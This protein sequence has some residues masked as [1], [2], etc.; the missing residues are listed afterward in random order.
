V[1]GDGP[2]RLGVVDPTEKRLA[3][4]RKAVAR[5]RS[6]RGRNDIWFAD[7]PLLGPGGGK[8]AFVFPG[9]E[10]ELTLNCG[11]VARHFG[12]PWAHTDAEVGDVGRQG[13]AVFELGR[14]LHGALG[15]LGV[16]P[17]AVAG[18]SLG[19]WTAMAAAGVYAGHEVDAFL[20]GF[21]PDTL[22]VPG[23][24]F[25]AVGAPAPR[26]LEELAGR[27]DVVLSHDNSPNQAMICGPVAAVDTLVARF[28]TGGIVAQV[29]PFRSGFHTPMLRPYLA[30]IH[31]AAA[32]FTLH[33]PTRPLWSATTVSEYPAAEAEV[34][35]LF[36]RHL[37]EPVRFRPL[38]RALH[39]AGFRAFVQVG[40]GQLGSLVGDTLHGEDHLVV[41]AHSAH[42]PGLAQ[43]RRVAT[44]LWADGLDI[45]FTRLPGAGEDSRATARKAVKL[46]LGGRLI[47][48]DEQTRARVGAR[49]AKDSTLAGK[50]PLA[51]EFA[52]LLADTADLASTVLSGRARPRRLPPP[53]ALRTTLD[54]SVETMPYLLDHCFFKQPPQ[55]DPGD[56]WPVVPATTVIDHLMGFAEQT[57]PG[58]RAVAVHDVRLTQW[59]A[60]V[61]AV[62]VPVRVE[63]QGADRVLAALDGYSQA[64]VELA[65]AYPTD[66]PEPWRFPAS[67]EQVPGTTAAELY[68]DRWMFHGPRFQGVTELTAVGEHHVRAVLTTPAAPGA[69]LDNVGQVLGYWIMARFPERT[70]VFPVGMREIRFHGPHPAPG[71]RLECLVRI[72][73]LTEEFL[74]A[75]MQLV[76]RGQVWAEFTGWRDRRFDSTRDIRQADRTPERSTLSKEQPGGW[77]L[78]REQWP[79]LATRELI[80]RNYLAGSERDAYDSRPPRGRRQWLLGRIAAKDAVRQFLWAR[81]EPEMFPAELRIGNDDAGRPHATGAYGRELPELTISV[82]HKAETGVAI[83]R[84]GPCGIDV[85]EV[86]P[87]TA[88]TVDAALGAGEQTLF[89]SLP[90]DPERWF[91]RFW[92]AKEAVAKLLGTGLRGEPRG[93]EVVAATEGELTVR[94]AGR[95][96]RVC[97]AD[98]E[99][100]P[101]APPRRYVVAWTEETKETAE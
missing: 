97:C 63:P 72:T 18:H 22:V 68:D 19:E 5:G 75:D 27:T 80:M 83:A 92:T 17:D 67:A 39:T 53:S 96:H 7:R 8:L 6:W 52:A 42:R 95:D 44:A 40:A 87:R 84:F 91:A 79:D 98:I 12:L 15:R 56:R 26:V 28:R 86:A 35:E 30:P 16:E 45:D 101:G 29:L 61:P 54:V 36:V 33:P 81:G 62:S 70:T 43:L 51:E 90:G 50:G 100:P 73:G 25:A 46:D 74:D 85:D 37:L 20:A 13:A 32:R 82:A 78:V 76:H 65:P 88:S 89:A 66:A 10:S 71:E 48:L 59:I 14:L 41:A 24:A 21:D 60:A 69:L 11:D 77:A 49:L 38:V 3:L 99:N 4:A 93:F 94:A 34:R 23:L 64:V 2:V 57:A 1:T 55:A 58:R 31:E 9:L 47:S